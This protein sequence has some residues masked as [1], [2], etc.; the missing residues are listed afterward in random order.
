M[1]RSKI[2]VG[3]E[4]AVSNYRDWWTYG[5]RFVQVL[6]TGQWL[7][8]HRLDDKARAETPEEVQNPDM[9]PGFTI[10]VPEHIRRNNGR[11]R[12]SSGNLVLVRYVIDSEGGTREYGDV[13]LAE[14]RHLVA[15]RA[16][17]EQ[18]VAD[19]R[20]MRD[21]QHR[22]AAEERDLRKAQEKGF[23]ERLAAFGAGPVVPA[24]TGR[25]TLDGATLDM[26]LTLAERSF[27][28]T[29]EFEPES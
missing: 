10:Q 9:K 19:H 7:S 16:D 5:V 15:E 13:T 3:A 2:K 12:G 8:L 24:S 14:T 6:D 27:E 1:Q 29:R 4:Y 22:A 25:W 28:G 17:A 11:R 21:E 23:N 20:A 18:R 26:L